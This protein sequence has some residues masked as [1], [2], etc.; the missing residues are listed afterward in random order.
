MVWGLQ[1]EALSHCALAYAMADIHIKTPWLT[2]SGPTN[3]P[4]QEKKNLC[5]TQRV[6]ILLDFFQSEKGNLQEA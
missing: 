1:G 2:K 5:R 6:I 4:G 3:T